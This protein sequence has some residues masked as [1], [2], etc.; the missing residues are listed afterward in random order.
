MDIDYWREIHYIPINET[1]L[2]KGEMLHKV[3]LIL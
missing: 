2:V 1:V 3:N